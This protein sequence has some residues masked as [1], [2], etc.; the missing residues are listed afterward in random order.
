MIGHSVGNGLAVIGWA[1]DLCGP[2]V[3]GVQFHTQ[4]QITIWPPVD[5]DE[6]IRG[7]RVLQRHHQGQ[8]DLD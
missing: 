2:E 3:V 1:S 6:L 4:D 5:D 7:Q 8:F